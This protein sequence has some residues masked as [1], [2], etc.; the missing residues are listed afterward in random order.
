MKRSQNSRHFYCVLLQ[1]LQSWDNP[2]VVIMCRKCAICVD[3]S[4]FEDKANT[5]NTIFAAR[6]RNS[7]K[8][9]TL[10]INNLGW[11]NLEINKCARSDVLIKTRLLSV[12]PLVVDN[13]IIVFDI[14]TKWAYHR[15]M[16]WLRWVCDFI[17]RW[18]CDS[19]L[20]RE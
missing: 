19:K 10:F 11:F 16:T 2:F 15:Q 12:W 1:M 3:R 6:Y 8:I 17:L 20:H 18:V 14:I 9:K 13:W 5:A 4:Q 7:T